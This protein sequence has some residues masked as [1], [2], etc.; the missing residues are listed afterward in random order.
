MTEGAG[1]ARATSSRQAL[2]G[3]GH[4]SAI[5]AALAARGGSMVYSILVLG[6]AARRVDASTAAEFFRLFN[7]MAGFA[8]VQAGL[9]A[10]VL[11][12]VTHRDR[13]LPDMS[14]LRLAIALSGL[15]SGL[16]VLG[17]G[18]V[19]ASG[20]RL[21]LVP[22]T[23]AYG[24]G[25]FASIS[26]SIRTGMGRS[27]VSN[28]YLCGAYALGFVAAGIS[29][30][31]GYTPRWWLALL[32]YGVPYIGFTASFIGLLRTTEFRALLQERPEWKNLPLLSGAIPMMLVSIGS[33]GVLNLP[34]LIQLAAPSL[35]Q[36]STSDT[37]MFRIAMATVSVLGS[38]LLA[39]TPRF[40]RIGYEAGA[41]AFQQG[42]LTLVASLLGAIVVSSI[43]FALLG[44]WA[45][46]VWFGHQ[47]ASE[48][49]SL[50]W[51]FILFGWLAMTLF[52]QLAQQLHRAS[53]VAGALIVMVM[54]APVLAWILT[55]IIR[56]S[57][58]GLTAITFL[59][60]AAVAYTIYRRS[61][62]MHSR[63][64]QPVPSHSDRPPPEQ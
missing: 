48:T 63:S 42:M 6:W 21:Y 24:A 47:L 56:I 60:G 49:F 59:S 41:G 31:F 1:P 4:R 16:A 53:Q 37:V 39:L 62:A 34:W 29:Q 32:T 50:T 40:V 18:V 58:T 33:I 19:F 5:L 13:P 28:L 23:I 7:I 14:E 27:H 36:I 25:S 35:R 57:V 38:V 52:F 11:R 15:A 51:G 3:G 43:G 20:G 46:S 17:F 30:V 10:V 12:R 9:A 55:G 2:A 8:L 44:R 64:L 45:A 61:L 54:A 26:D 22:L